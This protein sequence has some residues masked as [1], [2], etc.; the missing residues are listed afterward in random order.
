MGQLRFSSFLESTKKDTWQN[1]NREVYGPPREASSLLLL[2]S[3]RAG[4]S[5]N[6]EF[7][8]SIPV[9]WMNAKNESGEVSTSGVG[10]LLTRISWGGVTESWI[11]G[12]SAGAYWPVGKLGNQDLPATATFSTGTVDPAI[13]AYMSGPTLL[14]FGWYSSVSSR[15]V[16]SERDDGSRLGS[17][18]TMSLGISRTLTNRIDGQLLL[19][20][21][22]RDRDKGNMMEDTGGNWIYIQP[23]LSASLYA[24]PSYAFQVSIG[25]R[26]PLLQRVEGTQLVESPNFSF[27]FAH[28][29]SL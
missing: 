21:F 19:T 4:L 24:K 23:F 20:Y 25:A 1:L 9:A 11:Y 10:D 26:V 16:V 6:L 17:S 2:N 7:E 22:V 5:K 8:V 27:G 14:G 28:T 15:L 18:Y 3:I 29:I 13:G 12:V